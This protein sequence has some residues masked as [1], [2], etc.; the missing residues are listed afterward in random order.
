MVD[1]LDLRRG[2]MEKRGPRDGKLVSGRKVTLLP[3]NRPS[4]EREEGSGR[5][6]E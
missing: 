3:A 1:F 5:W 6:G 2:E 4:Y